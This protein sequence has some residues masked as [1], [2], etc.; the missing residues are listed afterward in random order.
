MG[1][2]SL[3]ENLLHPPVLFFMLGMLAVAVKSDLEIPP[4]IGKF[5]SL[6]LLFVIGIKGGEELFHSGFPP[7]VISVMLVCMLASFAMPF[8]SYLILKRKLSNADAAAVA[9]TYGSIS[10]VTFATAVAFLEGHQI[11]F[12]GYMVAAMALMESPAIVA[13]LIIYN[14][15]KGKP[16]KNNTGDDGEPLP[17]NIRKSF[18]KR[19]VLHEAL[20]NGSVFLL[21]GSLLIG[22]ATGH[23]GEVELKTFVNDMFKGMLCFYM[24]DMGLIA[25]RRLKDLKQSGVFLTSFSLLYPLLMSVIAI[26]VGYLMHLTP[27]N[28]L[29]LTILFSSA[30]Y[31]AVPA[32]MR[33]SVPE[34]NMSLV[35]P[36]ALGLTFTFNVVVGIPLYYYIIQHLIH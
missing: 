20:F 14:I 3:T 26:G 29:L 24:L 6:Y 1:L 28:T 19:S 2:S 34:A 8:V 18:S 36:M 35:L 12:G 11:P 31:I 27:G 21:V 25:G 10:A 15:N 22:Y 5:L 16:N 17:E 32:A 7:A 23:T 4:Q 30:S 13:G 33:N 9:A